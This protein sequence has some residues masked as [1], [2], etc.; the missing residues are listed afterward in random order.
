LIAASANAHYI[1]LSAIMAGVKDI[2]EAVATA[3]DL[4]RSNGQKTLLFIDEIHRFN[5]SQQDAFLPFVENGTIILVGATTENPS[6]S[7]NNAL[8]SRLQVYVL[9]SLSNEDLQGVLQRACNS[10]DLLSEKRAEIAE[11]AEALIE[12]ADGDAR[13]LLVMLELLAAQISDPTVSVEHAAAQIITG[14]VRRFDQQGD[15]F[16]DQ[17]SALHKSVRGSNPDA[18]L[19]WFCRMI[20]GGTDPHYLARR[21]VR[22]ASEDIGNAD[23]RALEITNNAWIAFERLGS[24]EGELALAQAVIFLALAAKSN[25][26]YN[27]YKQAMAD[28]RAQKTHPVPVHLCNAP[29]KLMKEL[30][31]GHDYRYA[32]DEPYAYAANETYFP[33]EM[34]RTQYYQPTDRG[35]EKKLA[36][37]MA[38]LK[39]LDDQAQ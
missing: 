37:K 24:P 15:H 11:V 28:V 9:K 16:Y 6:F 29:T 4:R 30:G 2:R 10:H 27:A 17:I 31:Y 20:D 36:E 26:V 3:G 32:H 25:A 12:S 22:I 21:L 1:G 19:Y 38:F 13:R 14:G 5:K 34:Q 18:A 23:P 35:M 39:Q 7:L 33:D 8:L